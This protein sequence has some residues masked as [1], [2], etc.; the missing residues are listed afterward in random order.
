MT[1][2][3][4]IAI[5]ER[6]TTIPGDGYTWEQIEEAI[7]VAVTALRS[8]QSAHI[9]R[10]A[11]E[12]CYVCKSKQCFNCWNDD[13][14][15]NTEPCRSCIGNEWRAKHKFCPECGRPMTEE[16]WAMLEK[17]LRG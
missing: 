1:N 7:N 14:S 13:L 12:P 5:L 2:E 6:K 17:R 15:M 10:E 9:D 3:E 11:W 4:A 16:A 8:N